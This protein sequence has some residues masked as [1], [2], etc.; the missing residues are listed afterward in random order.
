MAAL[1]LVLACLLRLGFGGLA[2][3]P[4]LDGLSLA[5]PVFV[6]IALV[7][8]RATGLHSNVWRYASV[9]D[10]LAII[11][12]VTLAVGGFLL[13]M[14][15]F[16]RLEPLPRSVPFIQWFVLITMMG[17]MRLAARSF[18]KLY[19]ALSGTV[20]PQARRPVLLFGDGDTV[21]LF[22]QAVQRNPKSPF[23]PVGVIDAE[24]RYMGVRMR[25]VPVMGTIDAFERIVQ[26]LDADGRRPEQLILTDP[27]SEIRGTK[28]QKLVSRA[29]N[30]SLDVA[31]VPSLTEL[32]QA[33]T[34]SID[35]KPIEL[36]DL[37]G[38]PQTQLDREPIIN[39]VK[40][41]DVL[42]T[43][44]GGSIGSELVRQI[45]ALE[46][47]RLVLVDGSEYNLYEIDLALR[48]LYPSVDR[49]PVLCNIRERE[50]V[51]SVFDQHEPELVFHAAA[52]KH[53]PMVELNSSEG[54]LTN[55]IGTRNVADAA[56]RCGARAMVQVSTDKAVNPTSVMG[57]SKR[58]AEYYCQALDLAEDK[59]ANRPRFITV[60]FGNVLG[61]SGSLI[62]LF[63]RQLERGGPLTVTHPEIKRY[64]M[65][66]HEAVQLVL[67]A[68]AF[69]L[70]RSRRSRGRIFVLD[71]GE[72][73]KIIDI[74]RRMIRL[75]GYKPDSE[76]KID[77]VGLR[78]GEKLT[79]E[80]FDSVE[81]RLAP[82]IPGVFEAMSDPVD[83]DRL[84]STFAMMAMTANR[85]DDRRLRKLISDVL[86]SYQGAEDGDDVPEYKIPKQATGAVLS[87]SLT[88]GVA[89]S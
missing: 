64:F 27:G 17:G 52:L 48:E 83:L 37:L 59:G 75:A 70:D 69:G 29:E 11:N 44:A 19:S 81:A 50:R 10:L 78:P 6:A 65:T 22:I 3:E 47:N 32:A 21:D 4:I 89:T 68:S 73:V 84:Q 45:A 43:G 53:V 85:N 76:I 61:S 35:L 7:T 88:S 57:A 13:V 18:F 63:L 77:I 36:V 49:R 67:Q 34:D 15:L 14:F 66:V 55:V 42:V 87:G 39:L 80:L 20:G 74:A 25:G 24:D 86:P 28:L 58:L 51:M 16:N 54:I 41:R 31:Q 33:S 5:L 38:R 1:S 30:L 12:A 79:E 9:S 40:G 46:P 62:P 60:R 23:Q 71:M 72:P 56:L 82:P 26:Q 2:A 8:F